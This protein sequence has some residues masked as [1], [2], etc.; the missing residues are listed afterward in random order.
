MFKKVGWLQILELFKS[1]SHLIVG[2]MKADSLR[3]FKQSYLKVK[4]IFLKLH[5]IYLFEI[6]EK[7]CIMTQ[8]AYSIIARTKDV[9]ENRIILLQIIY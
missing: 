3:N 5:E 2:Q 1:P 7:N 4:L 6:S 9:Y 8:R